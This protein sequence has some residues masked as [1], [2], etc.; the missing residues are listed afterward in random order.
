MELAG[1]DSSDR[2]K[3]TEQRVLSKVTLRQ[4]PRL[5]KYRVT[6][7]LCINCCQILK[8]PVK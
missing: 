3:K 6:L 1:A 7:I 2:R 5:C 4:E 8:K